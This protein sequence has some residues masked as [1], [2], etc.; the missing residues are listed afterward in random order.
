MN[1]VN[2]SPSV[3]RL[4]QE[5]ERQHAYPVTIRHFFWSVIK[6]SLRLFLRLR[7]T[8]LPSLAVIF[9]K[10]P[11]VF[12]LNFFAFDQDLK[13]RGCAGA[14]RQEGCHHMSNAMYMWV[15]WCVT[16]ICLSGGL[17]TTKDV[18]T[19]PPCVTMKAPLA[20]K[21]SGSIS[22]VHFPRRNSEPCLWF[23]LRSESSVIDAIDEEDN[24]KWPD[25]IHF[26]RKK[27]RALSLASATLETE[28]ATQISICLEHQAFSR[29]R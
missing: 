27:L 17:Q 3:T 28:Y 14:H 12:A 8:P 10:V 2:I 6:I 23:L 21:A 1:I 9:S 24:G 16:S 26:P 25:K 22:Q 29:L 19:N 4:L 11:S 20:R 5:L 18:S 7:F 15:F 13:S